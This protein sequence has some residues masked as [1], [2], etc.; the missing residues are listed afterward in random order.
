LAD[1]VEAVR[2]RNEH[3]VQTG[4]LIVDEFVDGVWNSSS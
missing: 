3:D 4:R 1:G 2:L